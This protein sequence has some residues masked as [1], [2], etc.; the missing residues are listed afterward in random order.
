MIGM[1]ENCGEKGEGQMLEE[2]VERMVKVRLRGETNL[3][4]TILAKD[5]KPDLTSTNCLR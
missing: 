2:G 3:D 4:N 5:T 1:R